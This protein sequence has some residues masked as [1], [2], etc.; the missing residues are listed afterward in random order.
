MKILAIC[1]SI[2][3]EKLSLMMDSFIDTKSN[4]TEIRI[5]DDIN[6]TVTEAFNDTFEKNSDYDFY[7]MA[8]DDIIF[9]T[10]EWDLKLTNKGK[11]SYGNDLLQGQYLC[12]F[13]MIDGDIVRA[14][15]WLQMPTLKRY[16]GDLSWKHI[17]TQCDCL[18]YHGNVFIKHHWSGEVNNETHKLDQ[19]EFV[20]WLPQSFKDIKKVRDVLDG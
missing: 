16:C 12:T 9:K 17:G 6:K 15:G 20:K 7:F 11:I 1:P 10:P 18:K 5:V 3:P 13:P 2:Y 19:I 8:N 4:N 14:L